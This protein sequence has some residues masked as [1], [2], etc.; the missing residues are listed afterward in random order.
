MYIYMMILEIP[1][2]GALI[3]ECYS[4]V[5]EILCNFSSCMSIILMLYHDLELY[6]KGF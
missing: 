5:V 1:W 2:F 4:D 6:V 3:F